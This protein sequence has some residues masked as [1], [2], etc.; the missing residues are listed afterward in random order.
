MTYWAVGSGEYTV[1]SVL[2]CYPE[3]P[4]SDNLNFNVSC[5]RPLKV[6]TNGEK[7]LKKFLSSQELWRTGL[8][9]GWVTCNKPYEKSLGCYLQGSMMDN[10][11]PSVSWPRP[12]KVMLLG[13]KPWRSHVSVQ[14][15]APL[16]PWQVVQHAHN[17]LHTVHVH[18]YRQ[19]DAQQ[20]ITLD[21]TMYY[22]YIS[23]YFRHTTHFIGHN[24]RGRSPLA[25]LDIN[26]TS[27]Y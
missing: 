22:R 18:V 1:T 21:T 17:P 3:S 24:T 15:Y 5:T 8:W 9:R 26:T 7:S 11:N 27:N 10:P 25:S 13:Q 6:R 23:Y 2:R 20:C 16:P 14:S 4:V 12:L 19:K